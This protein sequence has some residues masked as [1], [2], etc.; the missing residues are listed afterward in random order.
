M[1]EGLDSRAGRDTD[2]SGG[3]RQGHRELGRAVHRHT[4]TAKPPGTVEVP[5]HLEAAHTQGAAGTHQPGPSVPWHCQDMHPCAGPMGATPPSAEQGGKIS[6]CGEPPRSCSCQA[7]PRHR[8]TLRPGTRPALRPEADSSEG[9]G[10]PVPSLPTPLAPLP[11]KCL[12]PAALPLASW[13]QDRLGADTSW[14]ALWVAWLGFS[15]P[16][17]GS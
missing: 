2:T 10:I 17:A 12:C 6:R 7:C 5:F 3:S 16:A 15:Q 9:A 1:T 8:V 14:A 11:S 4:L 13:C